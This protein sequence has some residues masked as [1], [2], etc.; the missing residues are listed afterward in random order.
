MLQHCIAIGRSTPGSRPP[1]STQRGANRQLDSNE[2]ERLQS[3]LGPD[4][5]LCD[6]SAICGVQRPYIPVGQES[7]CTRGALLAVYQRDAPLKICVYFP[8]LVR[9]PAPLPQK[10]EM[11]L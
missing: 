7:R 11:I 10:L 3:E 1:I 8:P 9:D 5:I 2:C 6:G 4:V